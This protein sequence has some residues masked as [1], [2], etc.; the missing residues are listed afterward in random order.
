MVAAGGLPDVGATSI[1]GTAGARLGVMLLDSVGL[2]ASAAT[3]HLSLGENGHSEPSGSAS[4]H[5]RS[6]RG[7]GPGHCTRTPSGEFPADTASWMNF[8][9]RKTPLG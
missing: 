5:Q 1:L 4:G 9:R 8:Q 3:S 7:T 2:P 6:V